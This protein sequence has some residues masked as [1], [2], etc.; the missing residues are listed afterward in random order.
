MVDL[1][2]SRGITGLFTSLRSAGSLLE[3]T[4][5]AL[6]SLMD[7][8][9]R[10]IDVEANGERNR[11]LY[12]IKSRGSSHSNQVREYRLTDAGIELIDVYIGPEG[13]LTGTARLAQETRDHA[14]AERRRREIDRRSRELAG[15]R[16]TLE[17]E[18]AER[19]AAI[20]ADP[21]EA[22]ALLMDHEAHEAE[23]ARSRAATA[24]RRGAA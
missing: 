19:R 5:H 10:L 12:I 24:A 14:V 6:S 11:V 7:S 9:I 17:R 3:G 23:L 1:L 4:D 18:I 21:D 8:W 16:A 13:V 2:K 22:Q 15:R 20:E